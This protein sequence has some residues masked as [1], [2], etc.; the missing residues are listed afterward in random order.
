MQVLYQGLFYILKMILSMS[1]TVASFRCKLFCLIQFCSLHNAS[2]L[3]YR[4]IHLLCISFKVFNQ[5]T[6]ILTFGFGIYLCCPMNPIVKTTSA[7]VDHFNF[8]K[9]VFHVCHCYSYVYYLFN[10]FLYVVWCRSW[11][12]SPSRARN[13]TM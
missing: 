11:M 9:V 10:F 12:L 8:L 3:V 7:S 1:G 2:I 13:I 5:Y 6:I 4:G